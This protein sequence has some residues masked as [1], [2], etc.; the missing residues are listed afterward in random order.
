MVRTCSSSQ[1]DQQVNG[2]SLNEVSLLEA[3]AEGNELEQVN[4]K[5]NGSAHSRNVK[6]SSHQIFFTHCAHSHIA[7]RS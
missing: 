7:R 4:A 1:E 3:E 5:V 6:C 2:I